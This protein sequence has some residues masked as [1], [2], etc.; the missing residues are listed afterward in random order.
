[1]KNKAS[2][3]LIEKKI[4]DILMKRY[5]LEK[6]LKKNDIKGICFYA[7]SSFLLFQEFWLAYFYLGDNN[8]VLRL[9]IETFTILSM[10]IIW[11]RIWNKVGNIIPKFVLIGMLGWVLITVGLVP[12][13]FNENQ[14]N[15]NLPIPI[16][17]LINVTNDSNNALENFHIKPEQIL[18]FFIAPGLAARQ[19]GQFSEPGNKE[20]ELSL[21]SNYNYYLILRY[22]LLLV[23]VLSI[24]DILA[25]ISTYYKKGANSSRSYSTI[26]A[27]QREWGVKK[28]LVLLGGLLFIL[29]ILS[30]NYFVLFWMLS[31]CT[32]VFLFRREI[33]ERGSNH[34]P[35]SRS[36]LFVILTQI[37]SSICGEI[38]LILFLPLYAMPAGSIGPIYLLINVILGWTVL[39]GSSVTVLTGIITQVIW[40][41]KRM[42]ESMND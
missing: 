3:S 29:T 22:I 18:D 20:D 14:N 4:R 15:N 38:L 42:T 5:A 26:P 25:T 39:L 17:R 31:F 27:V 34:K 2:P 9:I 16:S 21:Y 41:G 11:W 6:I 35:L 10:V 37:F 8:P 28:K 23:V 1:M 36:L 7:I 13:L 12:N 19:L 33:L 30:L 32:A 40:S 24:I